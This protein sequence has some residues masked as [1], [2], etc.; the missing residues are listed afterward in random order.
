M[1]EGYSLKRLD[2]LEARTLRC[3][4]IKKHF[5][6]L[7]SEDQADLLY[8]CMYSM[9]MSMLYLKE[10][11]LET[12]E[13]RIRRVV[14]ELRPLRCPSGMVA[15]QKI[16]FYMAQLCIKNTCWLRNRLKIGL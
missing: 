3:A 2:A 8:F 1:G 7:V 6:E 13:S 14:K 12:A 16:W 10:T 15:M 11:D 9:Q 4:Y 5:P